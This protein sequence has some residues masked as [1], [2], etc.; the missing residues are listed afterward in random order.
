MK[1]SL[2]AAIGRNREIGKDN[3]LMWNLPDDMRFFRDTTLHHH[4]IMGRK[5]YDSIPE[6]Y[7]PLKDRTNLILSR[8][9][10]FIAPN[11]V[12]FQTIEQAFAYS[13]EAGETELFV[14]GGAQVYDL[15]LQT[16][17]VDRMYLTFVDA[18]FESAD[19]FFPA[20]NTSDWTRTELNKKEVDD[21]HKFGF[22]IYR[23]D[24][25]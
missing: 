9:A 2:I 10:D 20:F 8:N 24:R 3:D 7:R 23:F 19:T 13:V 16:G 25:K 1:I 4:I 6:K 15:A 18:D 11:C 12:V 14:I 22:T 17:K 21:R 5:N